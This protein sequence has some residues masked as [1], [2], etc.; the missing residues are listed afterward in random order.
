MRERT[1]NTEKERRGILLFVLFVQVVVYRIS[2]ALDCKT[3][4]LVH[5]WTDPI[6]RMD[7]AFPQHEEEQTSEV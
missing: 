6:S 4:C 7:L 3:S 2:D 5:S 1:R